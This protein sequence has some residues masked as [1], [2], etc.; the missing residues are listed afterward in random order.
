MVH[1]VQSRWLTAPLVIGATVLLSA[2]GSSSG[3]QQAANESSSA[4]RENNPPGD[5]PDNQVF[6]PYDWPAGG[7]SL[8]VPEGWSRTETGG[9]TVFTDKLNTVRIETRSMPQA[10]TVDSANA[11]EL[12]AV[13]SAAMNFSPG[14]ITAIS[15]T[16]GPVVLMTYTADSPPDEVTGRVISDAFER[17]EFWQAG[18]EVVVTLSGPDGADNV[19]PWR[20]ITDSF[21]WVP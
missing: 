16:A 18:V 14:E 15:R 9:G 3:G 11:D 6:V 2:C 7:F 17:Y 19:D 12:P 5:I 13:A 20:I 4:V 8:T 1:R 10:P 21:Q